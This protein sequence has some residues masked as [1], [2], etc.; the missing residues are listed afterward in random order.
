ML[1]RHLGGK[2]EF[3]IIQRLNDFGVVHLNFTLHFLRVETL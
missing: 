3:F 2:I 1:R